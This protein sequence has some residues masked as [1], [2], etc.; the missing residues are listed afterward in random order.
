MDHYLENMLSH[1][2]SLK[3]LEA[4]YSDERLKT[5]QII[6]EYLQDNEQWKD[7]GTMS[8]GGVKI[9]TQYRRKWHHEQLAKIKDEY[10]LDSM[11]FPFAVEYK[12]IKSQSDYLA[13]REP[14]IWKLIEPALS[15]CT[16]KPYFF[17]P[18]KGDKNVIA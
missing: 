10:D 11:Q 4:H 2:K 13:E 5:E 15:L 14:H 6:Q 16:T 1:W 8:F 17:I 7:A 3:K 18:K 12:E 9:R